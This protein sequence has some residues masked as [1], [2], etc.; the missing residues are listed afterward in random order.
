MPR[1]LPRKSGFRI[2]AADRASRAAVASPKRRA[3]RVKGEKA[4]RADLVTRKERPNIVDQAIP[5]A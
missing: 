4:S 1:G 3:S 5:A 2:P